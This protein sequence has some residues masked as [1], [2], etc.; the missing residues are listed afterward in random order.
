M[1][2]SNRDAHRNKHLSEN[3]ITRMQS[4]SAALLDSFKSLPFFG[5]LTNGTLPLPSYINQLRAFAAI[6]NTLERLVAYLSSVQSRD[7]STQKLR[8]DTLDILQSVIRT[9]LEADKSHFMRIVDDLTYFNSSL[10]QEIIDVR[11][12]VD[13]LIAR[14]RFLAS[15]EPVCL[16][17]YLFT[18]HHVLQITHAYRDE[19]QNSFQADEENGATFSGVYGEKSR[20]YQATYEHLINGSCFDE[21]AF[22]QI[23]RAVNESFSF[24]EKIHRGLYPLPS[25]DG[26]RFSAASIN[27]EVSN[28]AVPTDEREVAAAT[29]AGRLCFEEFSYFEARYG[30]RGR[31]FA[32][33]DSAWLVTLAQL[34]HQTLIRKVLWFANYLAVQGLPRI[35]LERQLYYLHQELSTSFPDKPTQY[36]MLLEG[37]ELLKKERCKHISVKDFDSLS[38]AFAAM[39]DNELDGKMKGTGALIVSAVCDEKAAVKV[40]TSRSIETWLTNTDSFSADWVSAVEEIFTQ[41]R[42]IAVF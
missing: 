13:A 32:S 29:S 5:A 33:G 14:M 31:R 38:R 21:Q 7:N 3:V 28:H 34:D 1:T 26:M 18:L 23:Q 36:A 12:S 9:D 2:I 6:F 30:E 4:E 15:E 25:V 40:E 11:H 35:T 10:L 20:E 22:V 19:V 16:I 24:M 41:T 8:L 42:S 37:A 17:G 27:P 39:T